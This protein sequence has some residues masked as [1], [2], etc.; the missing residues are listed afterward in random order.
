MTLPDPLQAMRKKAS[1]TIREIDAAH[2]DWWHE[3]LASDILR[4]I[5][6]LEV[7]RSEAIGFFK[8]DYE[9]KEGMT[10]EYTIELDNKVSAI[11]AGKEGEG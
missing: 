3:E 9:Y 6:A 10:E 7:Y 11:L 2:F 8:S 1:D 4:L 5:K